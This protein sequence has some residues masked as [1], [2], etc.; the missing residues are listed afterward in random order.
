MP[1]TRRLS[2]P[3]ARPRPVRTGEPVLGQS[4]TRL[5]SEKPHEPQT[6]VQDSQFR[7]GLHGSKIPPDFTEMP[8]SLPDRWAAW[9]SCEFRGE[10]EGTL[11]YLIL[12]SDFSCKHLSVTMEKLDDI[13]DCYGQLGD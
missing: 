7:A 13:R 5:T 2:L 4:Y 1:A 9:A 8:A 3:F 12:P 11:I 10:F 6:L